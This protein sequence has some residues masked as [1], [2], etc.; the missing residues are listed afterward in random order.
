M[1]AM[2]AILL[3]KRS[4]RPDSKFAVDSNGVPLS[5]R[6]AKKMFESR[7]HVLKSHH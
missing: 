7:I 5:N 6:I 3:R 2:L 1:L 4:A